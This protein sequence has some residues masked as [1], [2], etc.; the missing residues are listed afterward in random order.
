MKARKEPP[1]T[2]SIR[3]TGEAIQNAFRGL[4]PQLEVMNPTH[5]RVS[6]TLAETAFD[7]QPPTPLMP[8]LP[9][10]PPQPMEMKESDQN[11]ITGL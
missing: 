2:E 1:E 8:P 11:S 7:M 10:P 5:R 4:R 9:S 6:S 3:C